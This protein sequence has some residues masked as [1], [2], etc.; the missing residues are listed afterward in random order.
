MYCIIDTPAGLI[1]FACVDLLTPRRALGIML[2]SEKVFNL[3]QIE[4]TQKRIDQRW[5]ESEAL[6]R[7]LSRFPEPNII[8]GDF[9][10]TVDS[11]IYRDCWSEY[12]N[13]FS[14]TEFGFKSYQAHENQS[15]QIHFKD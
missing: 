5:L 11:A 8:A 9:N 2:D 7:W 3:S 13:A 6:S 10:L 12:Q 14:L 15:I 4:N 1:G